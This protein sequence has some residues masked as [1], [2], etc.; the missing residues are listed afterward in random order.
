METSTHNKPSAEKVVVSDDAVFTINRHTVNYIVI[1]LL[2]FIVGGIVGAVGYA[3]VANSNEALIQDAV[4]AAYAR[5]EETVGER[6]ASGIQA[7]PPNPN[8]NSFVD[9]DPSIG[10]VDAPVVIVEFSDFNCAFCRRFHDTTLQP[11]LERYAG[12]IRFVYRDFAILG[13][14]S[15][16]SAIAAECADDQGRFWDYHDLLFANQGQFGRDS[17]LRYAEQMSL[18]MDQF[19]TCLDEQTHLDDV[20]ADTA[21]AQQIGA[22]GTPTF[23]IND[24]IVVGAQP[25]EVFAQIIDSLVATSN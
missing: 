2:F 24:Q 11:L 13:E 23:L 12:Q 9:D 20:R 19:T 25:F 3:S 4:D 18:D 6:L 22:R 14:T 8:A 10:P 1:A 16:T 7:G 15:F 21:A 5:F 17:L